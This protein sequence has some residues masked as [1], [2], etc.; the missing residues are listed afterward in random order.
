[1]GRRSRLIGSPAVDKK[2]NRRAKKAIAVMQVRLKW[3]SGTGTRPAGPRATAPRAFPPRPGSLRA[4]TRAPANVPVLPSARLGT[5]REF[6]ERRLLASRSCL[7][8][9]DPAG[10]KRLCRRRF[11]REHALQGAVVA[12]TW[13]WLDRATFRLLPRRRPSD[14]G[15]VAPER[16][17]SDQRRRLG[18]YYCLGQAVTLLARCS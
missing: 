4:P 11:A 5:E 17:L 7:S 15:R 8:R 18:C 14:A 12:T 13:G 1:M 9:H 3:A 2:R 16:H 6:R 10:L